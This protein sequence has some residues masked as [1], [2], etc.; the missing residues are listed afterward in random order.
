MRKVKFP[1]KN[2]RR[3]K[4]F[5]LYLDESLESLWHRCCCPWLCCW[6]CWLNEYRWT[7]ERI[8]F[9]W[10]TFSF[11]SRAIN[12]NLRVSSAV[13][14]PSL[15]SLVPFM[16]LLE[17]MERLVKYNFIDDSK[18]WSTLEAS[19]MLNPYGWYWM[20]ISHLMANDCLLAFL[21]CL[22]IRTKQLDGKKRVITD[23]KHRKRWKKI[24]R[25]RLEF[26]DYYRPSMNNQKATVVENKVSHF[27]LTA[28]IAFVS[29]SPASHLNIF[30]L[31]GRFSWIFYDHRAILIFIIT[32]LSPQVLL[33]RTR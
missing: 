29:Y 21:V 28:S 23:R 8:R 12:T 16:C 20:P 18:Y 27:S 17:G 13:A 5:N 15:P 3:Q 14:L 31:L 32:E 10:F 33:H 9:W 4:K 26:Y 25:G 24:I 7:C 2:A 19:R 1:H 30:W 11:S 22:R 6:C